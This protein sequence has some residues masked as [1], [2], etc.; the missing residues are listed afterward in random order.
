MVD[1]ESCISG[2]SSASANVAILTEDALSH[3]VI[4][5][6]PAISGMVASTILRVS[7]GNICNLLGLNFPDMMAH[8]LFDRLQNSLSI[9][10][11]WTQIRLS[12]EFYVRCVGRRM[13]VNHHL[14]SLPSVLREAIHMRKL[15]V[16]PVIVSAVMDLVAGYP[17]AR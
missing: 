3:A 2:G 7:S 1:G 16:S 11:I 8:G 6:A 13:V 10:V 5:A 15:T 9:L 4:Q 12:V 17:L 14:A